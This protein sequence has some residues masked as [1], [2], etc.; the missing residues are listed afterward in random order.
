MAT[1]ENNQQDGGLLKGRGIKEIIENKSAFPGI[2]ALKRKRKRK[3]KI[4][5]FSELRTKEL[6][7]LLND[8]AKESVSR[9][10]LVALPS[11]AHIL[12]EEYLIK[13]SF[14]R[15]LRFIFKFVPL[16]KCV[17]RIFLYGMA[18]QKIIFVPVLNATLIA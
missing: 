14:P 4:I 10:A 2:T 5:S 18:A 15:I 16:R 1:T 9:A 12:V 8:L 6:E 11:D 17:W 13:T 7:K 3:T